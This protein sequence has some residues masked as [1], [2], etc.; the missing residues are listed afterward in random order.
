METREG[1]ER[2]FPEH[3][4]FRCP[5]VGRSHPLAGHGKHLGMLGSARGR[6]PAVPPPYPRR[7]GRG[8]QGWLSCCG[9][10]STLPAQARLEGSSSAGAG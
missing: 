4:D 6:S 1:C 2:A 10:L 5:S 3:Q 7:Q 9:G 8:R